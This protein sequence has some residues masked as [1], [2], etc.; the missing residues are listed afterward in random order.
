M[1]KARYKVKM[2]EFG[3]EFDGKG[4]KLEAEIYVRCSRI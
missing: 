1:F 4:W 3:F 2:Q